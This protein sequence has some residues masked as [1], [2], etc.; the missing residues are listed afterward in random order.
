MCGRVSFTLLGTAVAIVSGVCGNTGRCTRCGTVERE[1]AIAMRTETRAEMP[2]L[3]GSYVRFCAEHLGQLEQC[4]T[5][6]DAR[7]VTRI[8]GVLRGNAGRIGLSELASLGRE[9]EEYCLGGDWGAID[10]IYRAIADTV[11]K[12]CDG[13]P[14]RIGVRS[15]G[16]E[17]EQRCAVR[18]TG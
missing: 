8:A 4:I 7:A 12:L 2:G 15:H 1:P 14:V 10:S 18:K 17:R 9:L 6:H 3:A 16:D 11:S 5:T 13:E